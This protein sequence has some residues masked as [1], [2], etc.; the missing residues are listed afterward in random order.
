M[1]IQLNPLIEKVSAFAPATSANLG[2]GFDI[3]GLALDAVGDTVHLTKRS[4]G[5]IIIE[6][7]NS[8]EGLPLNSQ[9]NTAS[10]AL[11]QMCLDLGINCGFSLTID[12]GIAIG[13]GMGGSAA[14]AVAAVVAL[15]G[16]LQQPVDKSSLVKY[17]LYGEEL[18]SGG[19][20]ADNVAPCVFGGITL[21]HNLDPLA[22]ISLPYPELVA[23]IIHPH[24]TVKTKEAR[25]ILSSNINLKQYIAQSAKL[26]ATI[27]A[28]YQQDAQLLSSSL[29]DLIIEPQRS[30][31]ITGF[32]QVKQAALE[33][34]ALAV[35]LSGSGP[36]LLALCHN[37]IQASQVASAMQKTF[38]QFQI[39][40]DYWI[41]PINPH[42]AHIQKCNC[43]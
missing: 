21:I 37:Q 17:A 3:L 24:L 38:S 40:S 30:Q 35:M 26:A 10:F 28:F 41:S 25:A 36:S 34:Q 39:A 12:K 32:N 18:A 16:F 4:D 31:L 15:N 14:S 7:I 13:S 33:Q 2:V 29:Q 20:H 9:Q 22:V 23:V 27:S 1:S 5:Q 42:G 19:R 43:S 11:Q 8:V 6:K